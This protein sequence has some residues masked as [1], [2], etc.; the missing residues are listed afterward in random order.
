MARYLR[1]LL[2]LLLVAPLLASAPGAATA[3]A[4]ACP[5]PAFAKQQLR[6]LWVASVSNINWPSR[7]GLSVAAQQA[8]YR[9][10]LDR[11]KAMRFNAV[12]VQIRPAADAFFPS[13][14]EP[15]SQYLTGVQGQDPGYDPL[16]FL[17]TEA[18][19]RGLEFHGW[20]NPYRVSTQADPNKLVPSHPARVNPGW[21]VAYGTQLYY[22]PGVPAVRAHVRGVIN[23]V[24]A[25]YDLDGVHFDDYFYPYPVAGSEFP[26]EATYRQFGAGFAVKADWRRDNVNRLIREVGADIRA[27]KPHVAFGVSPFGVWRDKRHDPT[28][29]ETTAG[30]HNYDDLYADTRTWIRNAWIDYVAPQVY[31]N[32]GYP[33]AA[34]DKLI[35]WWANEVSG[36]GVSLYIGQGAYKVGTANPAAWLDPE[37][38]PKHLSLNK[39]H[40]QVAGDIYYNINSV[41]ANPLGLADRLQAD[42]QRYPALIPVRPTTAGAAPGT[43]TGI[44]APADPAGG[45]RLTWQPSAGAAAYAVYRLPGHQ[46][47][48][49]CSVTDPAALLGVTR[50]PTFHDQAAPGGTLFTYLV[51]ALDRTHRESAPRPV[52]VP[53]LWGY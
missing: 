33:P 38:M 42:Q 34:Y 22:N 44:R 12:F 24:L 5:P 16:A 6:G 9:R 36:T 17:L 3:A 4:L 1:M 10:L 37:E 8:E 46:V 31:W 47:P 2:S 32:I 14:R 49:E 41:F 39:N 53:E 7:A 20:F 52:W 35:P 40:P 48:G 29:S 43:V 18:K 27:A 21:R 30:V 51:T 26:D 50:S 19:A 13:T 25:R 11:A 45:Y 23:D 28:G 15:W